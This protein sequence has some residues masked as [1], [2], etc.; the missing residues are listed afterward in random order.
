MVEKQAEVQRLLLKR[1]LGLPPTTAITLEPGSQLPD[2][3]SPPSF[4][5]LTEGLELRRLDL[6]GLRRGYESQE[7]TVRGRCWSSSP[8]SASG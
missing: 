2:R 5:R 1:T 7:A 6:V 3:W 4:D 8:T